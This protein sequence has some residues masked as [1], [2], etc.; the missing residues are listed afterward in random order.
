MKNKIIASIIALLTLFLF[1][2]NAYY[3]VDLAH[4]MK[5][6]IS[7]I[8]MVLGFLGTIYFWGKETSKG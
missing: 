6:I 4:P 1:M 2:P 7:F 5:G 3:N 8:F